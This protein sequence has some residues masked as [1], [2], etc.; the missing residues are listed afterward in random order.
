MIST[1]FLTR[2]TG[3]SSSPLELVADT[4]D[5]PIATALDPIQYYR[6]TP[7]DGQEHT[8]VSREATMRRYSDKPPTTSAISTDDRAH[9]GS[10]VKTTRWRWEDCLIR[11]PACD[12]TKQ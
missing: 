3:R 5:K 6:K 2:F 7:T 9:T 1:A 11:C 10:Y 8:P 4:E 12:L